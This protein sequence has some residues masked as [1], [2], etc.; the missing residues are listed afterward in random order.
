M[1][2][3]KDKQNGKLSMI[4][5]LSNFVVRVAVWG[6]VFEVLVNAVLRSLNMTFDVHVYLWLSMLG[7]GISGKVTQKAFENKNT[8]TDIG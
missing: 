1:D 5:K 4:R 3:F 7:I 6:V 2:Q 8:G